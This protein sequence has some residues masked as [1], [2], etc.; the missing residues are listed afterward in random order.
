LNGWLTHKFGYRKVLVVSLMAITAFI[1]PLFFAPSLAVLL[2][3]LILCGVPWG[4]FA[5][6][7]PAYASEI[8]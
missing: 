5:T 2:V 4:V 8:W 3:G 1:F 6:M 7:A